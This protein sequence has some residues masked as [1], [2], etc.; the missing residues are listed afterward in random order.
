MG[1]KSLKWRR[2]DAKNGE[3]GA[4][5]ILRDEKNGFFKKVVKNPWVE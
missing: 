5:P 2:N 3:K 4:K 1:R